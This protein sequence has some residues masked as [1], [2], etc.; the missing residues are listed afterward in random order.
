MTCPNLRI[1][2]L[3]NNKYI[4]SKCKVKYIVEG[5]FRIDNRKKVRTNIHKSRLYGYPWRISNYPAPKLLIAIRYSL[6]ST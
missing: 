4:Y 1:I 6:Y 5:K 3:Q 2:Q